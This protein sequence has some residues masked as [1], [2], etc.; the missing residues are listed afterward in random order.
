MGQ[1]IA[2]F[3]GSFDPVH[4]G[5]LL[6]AQDALTELGLDLLV[7]VPAGVN[8]HKMQTAPQASGEAR[9]EMLQLATREE[10]RFLVDPLELERDGPSF[11]VDTVET[12]RRRWPE[13]E[14]FLLLGEDNLP[15]LHTWHRFESLQNL[16]TFVTFGRNTSDQAN[17][18]T[19]L[20]PH[21]DRRVDI[22]S[23][24]IRLRIA[25]GLPIR[26][27]IPE[28]VRLLIYSHVL[29]QSSDQRKAGNP[30]WPSRPE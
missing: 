8:P 13:A 16:V 7:F 19:K 26:Y 29:Y 6:L 18:A 22:S 9:L 4:H 12:F 15:K 25:Q 23:T 5:H 20:G 11:T 21:L 30:L 2:I 14:L 3:G 27:L 10:A 28:P 17:P 24:E 1:R